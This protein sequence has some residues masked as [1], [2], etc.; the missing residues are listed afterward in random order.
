MTTLT[1]RERLERVL[2]NRGSAW[3]MG[4]AVLPV[5]A[6]VLL[7]GR[8]TY[9][10]GRVSAPLITKML[11]PPV[12]QVRET[13]D[14]ASTAPTAS[15]S[16]FAGDFAVDLK[17]QFT[18]PSVAE[19][20]PA[21]ETP[22]VKVEAPDV[23]MN[24]T[25]FQ[26]DGFSFDSEAFAAPDAFA[27]VKEKATGG[28][29]AGGKSAALLRAGRER[30]TT[31][32]A[33]TGRTAAATGAAGAGDKSGA[34]GAEPGLG[35]AVTLAA[36]PAGG[37]TGGSG[38]GVNRPASGEK[39]DLIG[40]ILKNQAGLRPA[41]QEAL[42][43]SAQKSDRTAAGSAVDQ[44]GRLYQFFF[45]HRTE[46]NLLRILVVQ[47]GRA[48]RID[49]PDFY[50][51]ANHVQAGRAVR[52]PAGAGGEPGPIIEVALE[53]VDAVPRE[54][55]QMFDLVLQWLDVKGKE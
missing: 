22:A 48:W 17:E 4:A 20:V 55:P 2:S 24:E 52:G 32:A 39:A 16:S 18:V 53:S 50:L 12:V 7:L 14:F 54:V 9:E 33:G 28:D 37:G 43:F 3:A 10:V 30:T 26:E 11:T 46:N 27:D 35:Q 13:F 21:P 6:L 8:I 31:A 47:G 42:G 38:A 41:V 15:F 34:V 49:L 19:D 40:W 45:L 29:D 1:N 44:D 36:R 23:A 5:L 25:V 51:E